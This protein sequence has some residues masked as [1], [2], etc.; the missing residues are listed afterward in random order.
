MSLYHFLETE[1]A[2]GNVASKLRVI[3][4]TKGNASAL[5][6][7]ALRELEVLLGYFCAVGVTMEVRLVLGM[8]YN[9]NMY[10][11]LIFQV[12]ATVRVSIRVRL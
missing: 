8:P 11:G 6:K 10:N 9:V 7:R 12:A 1:G 3:T 2:Y 5:A 4:K